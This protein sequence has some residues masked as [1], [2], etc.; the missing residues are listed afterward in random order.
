MVPRGWGLTAH[1]V[2][3]YSVSEYEA[4]LRMGVPAQLILVPLGDSLF[5]LKPQ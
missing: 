4:R 1:L 3:S 2:V 5:A